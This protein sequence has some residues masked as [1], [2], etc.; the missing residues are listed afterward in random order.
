M[1]ALQNNVDALREQLAKQEALLEQQKSEDE[2]IMR[3]AREKEDTSWEHN[4]NLLKSIFEPHQIR[5][6]KEIAK[7]KKDYGHQLEQLN[8]AK[9]KIWISSELI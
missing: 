1:S 2:R 6:E 5:G 9:N 8:N 7:F 4:I 3:E